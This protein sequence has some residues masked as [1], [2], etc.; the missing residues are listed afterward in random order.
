VSRDAGLEEGVPFREIA[1]VIGRR[2]NL[3]VVSISGDDVGTHF[4]WF[5]PF[6]QMDAAAL[7]VKTQE[8]L[9]WHP[10]EPL[11]LDDL[12]SAAYFPS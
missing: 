8:S 7:S 9:G 4:G 10:T 1:G 11:L 5:A 12:D 3:P 2:T 6:A